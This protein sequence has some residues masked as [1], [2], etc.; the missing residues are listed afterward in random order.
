MQTLWQDVRFGARMLVKKPGFTLIAVL[1]LALG[2]GLNSAFFS[3]INAILLKPVNLPE[4]NRTVTIWETVLSQGIERNEAAPAN[5]F[6]WRD[7]SNSFEQVSLYTWWSVNLSAVE[8][9]ERLRG[10]RATANLFD[11]LGVKPMLGRTFKPEE[12]ETG[13][14]NVAILTHGL[15]QRRFA[16]D[17]QIVGKT[18]T[19]NGVAR[20]IVG[21]LPADLNY[22]RGGEVFA[23]LV[24]SPELRQSRGNH[25]YLSVARMKDGVSVQQAQA[26]LSTIMGRLRQQFPQSNT[27]RDVVVRTVLDDTVLNYSKLMPAFWGAAFFVLLIAC[28]NVANLMLARA[29]GRTKEISV[30]LALGASRWRIVRQMLTESCLLGLGG[31][32]MGLLVALWSLAAFKAILPDDAPAMMPGFEQLGINWRVAGYATLVSLGA[33]FL[34]GLAPA[35]QSSRQDLNSTLKDSG[36]RGGDSSGRNRL[37]SAFVVAEVALALILLLGAGLLMN[38]FLNLLKANPGFEP[39]NVLTMSLTIPSAKYPT[40]KQRGEFYDRLAER[41]NAMP[42]VESAGFI[43]HL[44]LGQ[45]NSSST[46]LIEGRPEPP[47]GQ[48]ME[49]R[50]RVCTPLYF[51]TMRIPLLKGRFFNDRDT[52]D[53]PPVIIINDQLA[54]RYWPANNAD[55]HEAVGKRMR[56]A[57]EIERNPWREIVGVVGSVRHELNQPL[58]PDYFSPQ[59]QDPWSTMFL[60][61]RTQPDPLTLVGA[62]RSEIKAIDPDQPVGDVRTMVAVR[63]RS[64]MHFRFSSGVMGVFG[65][66]ALLLAA[67]GIYGVM[68]YAVSQRTHEIGVRMA[69]GATSRSVVSLMLRQGMRLIFI[70]VVIGLVGGF[71]LSQLLARLLKLTN[72]TNWLTFAAVTLSLTAVAM[73]AC[74]IPARRATKVDPMIALR[75]E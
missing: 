64:I 50:E 53:A 6:D 5:Y 39:D 26:D 38:S 70:G 1:T 3:I 65:F 68:S 61:A 12:E 10:F 36:G 37:R 16:S 60:A 7:Q 22:P 4:L 28:A 52:A 69:L 58:S 18:I 47:P 33:G 75:C 66:F 59:A 46:F 32:T 43:S 23:P 8:P 51:Q 73:L 35:W 15:W 44:P 24:F 9:P 25:G 74:W 57:G 45:S 56:L 41:I 31:G 30:R 42:G 29:S 14:D 62:I 2:I 21:V 11:A 48:E 55:G 49:G 17:P 20:T 40:P 19:L 13:K 27:G 71:G 63:D 72:T 54:K 34:F 67:V